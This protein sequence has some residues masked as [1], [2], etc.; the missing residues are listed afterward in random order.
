MPETAKHPL[1]DERLARAS[2]I[3]SSWYTDPA[4]LEA[5]VERVFGRTW[6]LVGTVEQVAEPGMYFT[7]MAAGEPIVVVKGGDGEI[8]A[9]SNVCRHRA[10]PVAS[11]CGT[12][13]SFQCGYH[14]WSYALD[15]R[16]LAMPEFEGVED[17]RKEDHPLPRFVLRQWGPMLFVRVASEGPGFDSFVGELA[18][19]LASRPLDTYRS[20]ARKEWVIQCNWKVYVDNYL[21][22]YHIP[23]VHPSL[24]KELD[25][26][27]YRTETARWYSIQHSPIKRGE[28]LRKAPPGENSEAEFF[29]LYPNLMLNVYPDNFSTN[30]IVPLGSDRTL[31]QFEWFFR[32]PARESVRKMVDDTVVYSDEIQLEDIAI[33]EA[34]QKGLMSKTYSTGRYSV[35]RENGVHHFH[36]LLTEA[37]EGSPSD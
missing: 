22:G 18:A 20:A 9:L 6:Q 24:F 12:R 14:G 13:K 30:L 1:V 31:T 11:G 5:E 37:L 8:R 3:P 35:K 33:C 10:G 29:W 2:T 34:V 26:A 17:F 27:N 36:R 23:I 28:R 4:I 21:E 16:I 7:T 32:E 25:Y 19:R 15:G